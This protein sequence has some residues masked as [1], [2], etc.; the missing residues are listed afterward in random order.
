M[1]LFP[2]MTGMHRTQDTYSLSH[3]RQ[4]TSEHLD[5]IREGRVA[6]QAHRAGEPGIPA[7]E[8]IRDLAEE[9]GLEV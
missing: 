2:T 6:I 9:L 4:R 8:A 7:R 1:R 5:R 3:F